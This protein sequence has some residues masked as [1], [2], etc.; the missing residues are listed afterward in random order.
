MLP[1]AWIRKAN[2][3]R[4]RV[5]AAVSRHAYPGTHA[6]FVLAQDILCAY[7]IARAINTSSRAE[8]FDIYLQ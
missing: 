1:K 8:R 5:D 6:C 7:T 3:S 2:V 4:F